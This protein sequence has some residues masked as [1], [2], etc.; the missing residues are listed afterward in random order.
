MGAMAV[1]ALGAHGGDQHPIE[2]EGGGR[3][4]GQ[5]H[6]HLEVDDVEQRL[7]GER[8]AGDDGAEAQQDHGPGQPRRAEIA[9]ADA[10]NHRRRRERGQHG[11]DPVPAGQ[12]GNDAKSNAGAPGDREQEMK[13]GWRRA[14][15]TRPAMRADEHGEA[16]QADRDLHDQPDNEWCSLLAASDHGGDGNGVDGAGSKNRQ[17]SI[18]LDNE[19]GADVVGNT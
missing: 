10:A 3:H 7:A 11:D 4:R 1:L 8:S 13:V 14:V 15:G 6:R 19:R 5:I 12:A 16:G 18:E 17:G 9:E 2:A